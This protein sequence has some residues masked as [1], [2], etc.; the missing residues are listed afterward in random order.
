MTTEPESE[1]L[2]KRHIMEWLGLTDATYRA[3]AESLGAKKTCEKGKNLFRKS[4]VK[5]LMNL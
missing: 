5:K 3:M 1:F 2:R 4:E